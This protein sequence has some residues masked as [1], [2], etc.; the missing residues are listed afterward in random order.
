MPLAG[1]LLFKDPEAELFY[2]MDWSDWLVEPALI[3]ASEWIITGPDEALTAAHPTI[4]T[5]S[6]V[7]QVQL[8]G[9]TLDTRYT[10]TNRITTN[11]TIPQI[12][13]RSFAVLIYDR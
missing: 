6:Q 7:T 4:V 8:L 11:E 2:G 9:G 12:D 13:D 1:E 5:G 10:V 3:A